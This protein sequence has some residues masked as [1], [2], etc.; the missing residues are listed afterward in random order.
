MNKFEPVN[1]RRVFTQ[2]D[3]KDDSLVVMKNWVSGVSDRNIVTSIWDSPVL[4]QGKLY[5]TVEPNIPSGVG[6]A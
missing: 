1:K 4:K 5:R 3:N 6:L 2:S